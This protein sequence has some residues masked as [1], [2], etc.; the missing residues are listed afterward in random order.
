[1]KYEIVMLLKADSS[2]EKVD[3]I[4][5]KYEKVITTAKGTFLGA[6]KWGVRELMVSFQKKKDAT[7]AY[8]VLINIELDNQKQIVELNYKLKIDTDLIRHMVSKVMKPVVVE[9]EEEVA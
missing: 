5:A 9:T 7:K 4:I 1:M 6:E 8:Y 2:E 3:E